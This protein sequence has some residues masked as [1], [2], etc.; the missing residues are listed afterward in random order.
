MPPSRTISVRIGSAAMIAVSP[1]DP[2][3]G[4]KSWV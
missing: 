4:S 1:S 2:A 3:I